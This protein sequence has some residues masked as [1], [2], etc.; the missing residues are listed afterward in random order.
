[1]AFVRLGYSREEIIL[2]MDLYTTVG[3]FGGGPS[4]ATAPLRSSS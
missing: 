1:M 3:A 2:A 4:P